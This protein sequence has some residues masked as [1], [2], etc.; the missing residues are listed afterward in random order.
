MGR[1]KI[2]TTVYLTQEQTD[3][4]KALSD[5]T[6]VPI[7]EF[8]RQGVDHVLGRERQGEHTPSAVAPAAG[9]GEG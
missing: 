9:P 8:I 3:H 7:A 6:K 1:R 5:R 2:S 4:L